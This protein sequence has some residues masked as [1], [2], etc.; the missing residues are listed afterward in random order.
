M[1]QLKRLSIVLCMLL[2]AQH[3]YPQSSFWTEMNGG[4]SGGTVN[5]L[6]R[7]ATGVLFAGTPSGV[8]RS[9]TNGDSW[10]AANNG[11][12]LQYSSIDDGILS[13]EISP[14]NVIFAGGYDVLNRSTDEGLTWSNN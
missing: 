1:Q 14:D 8:Y 10:T 3:A 2:V 5:A 9:Q 4:L 11:I 12:V 6:A 7:S 13:L